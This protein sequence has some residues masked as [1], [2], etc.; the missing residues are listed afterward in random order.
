MSTSLPSVSTTLVGSSAQNWTSRRPSAVTV[1]LYVPAPTSGPGARASRFRSRREA[2]ELALVEQGVAPVAGADADP[3]DA[4]LRALIDRD[5]LG[6][7]ADLGLVERLQAPADPKLG[8]SA[9]PAAA[10]VA[11]ARGARRA[12]SIT[13]GLSVTGGVF[14]VQ[15]DQDG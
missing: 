3:A 13:A 9:Q 11:S 7:L 15:G 6:G 14:K 2:G 5:E 12:R 1:T 4:E 10:T 8:S